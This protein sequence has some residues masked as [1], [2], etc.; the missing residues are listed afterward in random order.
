MGDQHNWLADQPYP[1]APNI[2][3]IIIDKTGEGTGDDNPLKVSLFD[4]PND[5]YAFDHPFDLFLT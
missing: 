2:T 4:D 5:P 3:R 1:T